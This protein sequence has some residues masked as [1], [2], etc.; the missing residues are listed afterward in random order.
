MLSISRMTNPNMQFLSRG[1]LFNLLTEFDKVKSSRSR[2]R[3]AEVIRKCRVFVESLDPRRNG[4]DRRQEKE[5]GIIVFCDSTWTDS[6]IQTKKTSAIAIFL[7]CVQ[8]SLLGDAFEVIHCSCEI[9]SGNSDLPGFVS[10]E[11]IFLTLTRDYSLDMCATAECLAHIA[12][13]GLL[14]GS[15]AYENFDLL[16]RFCTEH[17]RDI[18]DCLS[19]LSRVGLMKSVH[20]QEN[21]NL[22]TQ[23]FG[24]LATVPIL[25]I[26][27]HLL[28]LGLLD[29][30]L[31]LL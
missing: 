18:A 31:K 6:K 19:L 20:A 22:L 17:T 24:R 1:Y 12:R 21:F 14:V 16:T 15:H 3:E 13:S 23:D 28:S 27:Q 7:A 30:V 5:L 10:M 25:I 26:L 29:Q 9:I 4:L 11:E 8:E 2:L